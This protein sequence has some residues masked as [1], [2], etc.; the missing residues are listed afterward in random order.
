MSCQSVMKLAKEHPPKPTSMG[1]ILDW[2]NVVEGCYEEA[3]QVQ[4]GYFVG[5]RVRNRS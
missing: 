3:E 4:S 5:A 2:I 1:T